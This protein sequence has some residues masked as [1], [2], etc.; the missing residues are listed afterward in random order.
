M[1]LP[2]ELFYYSGD[3]NDPAAQ[4]E[5]RDKF[6][7]VLNSSNYH[8]LCSSYEKCRAENVNVQCGQTSRRRRSATTSN[9]TEVFP[10][11]MVMSNTHQVIVEWD[12]VMDIDYS[13]LEGLT[14]DQIWAMMEDQ[15]YD[16]ADVLKEEVEDGKFDLDDVES[17]D[18]EVDK[19]SYRE[20]WPDMVCAQGT[21]QKDSTFS[22]S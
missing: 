12:I 5:I 2:N 19:S 7:A 18:L 9:L 11:I 14:T 6:I 17:L 3:C 13:K 1:N 8:V 10:E 20:G 21:T 15:M 16:M 22:C 4:Q